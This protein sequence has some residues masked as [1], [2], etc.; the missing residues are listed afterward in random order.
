MVQKTGQLKRADYAVRFS[1]VP[2]TKGVW[3][4]GKYFHRGSQNFAPV[5]WKSVLIAFR[6]R[7][8]IDDA[9]VKLAGGDWAKARDA[10]LTGTIRLQGLDFALFL[11]QEVEK[12]ATLFNRQNLDDPDQMKALAGVEDRLTATIEAM[13]KQSLNKKKQEEPEK[14]RERIRTTKKDISIDRKTPKGS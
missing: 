9:L 13:L 7:T 5:F 4:V 3:I 1:I 11:G 12:G 14:L 10:L 2:L 8:G 6:L